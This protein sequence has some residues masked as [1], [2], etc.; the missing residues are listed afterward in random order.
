MCGIAGFLTAAPFSDDGIQKNILMSMTNALN[1]RGPDADGFWLDPPSGIALGHRRLSILDLSSAGAQP[2]ESAD[3]RYVMVFNGEIYNHQALRID[4]AAD[5]FSGTWRGLSDSE[6]LIE[7]IALWGIPATLR[8]S[9]GMFAIGI[10]DRKQK[11]LTLAR[12]RIGEKPLHYGR[13]DKGWIF[14]SELKGLL[15]APGFQQNLDRAAIAEFLKYGYVPEGQCIYKNVNKLSPGCFVEIR[16]RMETDK[17]QRYQ[18]FEDLAFGGD[19]E[20]DRETPFD[21]AKQSREM[22]GLLANVVDEQML[23]DVPL[24]CFLSGGIDSSLVAS[25]MQAQRDTQIRTYS[26]GFAEDRFNEA[27][28]AAK[29]AEHLGT[30]HS[31]FIL[32][33][34]DALAIVPKLP[35]IY[36]EP[37]ADSSQIPTV[38]LCRAAQKS[39][40]VALTGD[41]ADEIFGGYNRH[42]HGPSIWEKTSKIPQW[43]RVPLGR[44]VG[45]LD[46]LSV[47]ENSLLRRFAAKTSLPITAIDKIAGLGPALGAATGAGDVY[48]HFVRVFPQISD[49]L[50]RKKNLEDDHSYSLFDGHSNLLP[51][52]WMMARDT[53]TYLPGDI[54]VKVDR[55][56]MSTSL[57]TRT[58]FLDARVVRAAWRLPITARIN[59]NTGKVILRDILYRHVPRDFIERPKQGFAVPIDKWLR[60]ALRDWADGLLSREDLLSLAGLGRDSVASLWQEHLEYRT[61]NGQKLWTVLMLLSWLEHNVESLSNDPQRIRQTDDGVAA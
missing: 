13:T 56:A 41:G 1:H 25:L 54:L 19:G 23:S 9:L 3:G 21:F 6:T 8:R 53:V 2:I 60:G 32:S 5:G 18:P 55:A 38:L 12:D 57:E 33:E 59:G 10:W 20:Q 47:S 39:V 45:K 31:E 17:V 35:Q 28:H 4:L 58:P 15:V 43:V 27:P 36:D 49:I 11:L 14:G 22:E 34:E 29:V 26:I 7:A 24:G 48:E 16:A 42:I 37:F 61:N 46:H 40:T 52:E 30:A 44:A 50:S 51:A